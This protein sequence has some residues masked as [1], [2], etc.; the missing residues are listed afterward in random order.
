[1]NRNMNHKKRLVSEREF[2]SLVKCFM[3]GNMHTLGRCSTSGTKLS[4]ARRQ[5]CSHTSYFARASVYPHFSN[6]LYLFRTTPTMTSTTPT[7]TTTLLSG[8]APSTIIKDIIDFANSPL[9]RYAGAYAVVLDNVLT[10]SEC[11]QLIRA[12]EARTNG[13][14]ERAMINVGGGRQAMYTDVRNCGRIIWDDKETM[15]RLW[16][17]CAPLVPELLEMEAD[18]AGKTMGL[19]PKGHVAKMTRL[20]ERM[21]FLKYVGGE[22][23]KSHCDGIYETPDKMERSYY[24]LHLYLND[25]K[26]TDVEP[27]LEGGATRFETLSYN[28]GEQYLDVNPKAGRVLIFQH[29][30]LMHSGADVVRGTKYTLRTDIMFKRVPKTD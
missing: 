29:R 19:W 9:P 28:Q 26:S 13:V 23:F 30:D 18:A 1:M 14:W 8:P 16:R 15:E 17:R 22:Y 27:L 2:V 10:P 4:L 7:E 25:E 24:T 5:N 3:M 21:R 20:N 12:A 6:I 11:T